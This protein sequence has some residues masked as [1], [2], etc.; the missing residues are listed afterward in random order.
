MQTTSKDQIRQWLES[1]VSLLQQGDI[2]G[3]RARFE[4]VLREQPNDFD[5]LNL[6]GVALYH[7]GQI[8][9]A[10]SRLERATRINP[11]NAG[12][13]SNLGMAL[14]AKGR[15]EDAV[16]AY[17]RALELAP[18]LVMAY[19][20]RARIRNDMRQF[21]LALADASRALKLRPGHA[22][23]LCLLGRALR[24]VGRTAEA[25]PIFDQAVGLQPKLAEAYVG[26]ADCLRQLKRRPEALADYRKALALRPNS[27]NLPGV[28]LHEQM[29]LCDWTDYHAQHEAVV[30]RVRKGQPALPPFV[31]LSILESA[32]LQHQAARAW[33]ANAGPSA[34]RPN[35]SA[36]KGPVR[37]GYF[38]ADFGDHPVM[39]LLLEAIALHDRSRFNIA[40]FT[41]QVKAHSRDLDALFDHV[42]DL[43]GLSDRDAARHAR[44]QG[45]DIAIDLDGHT[46]GARPQIFRHRAAPIQVSYLGYSGTAGA[47]HIDYMIA[48]QTIVPE[49]SAL[50]YS[51][52]MAWLPHCYMPRDRRLLPAVP[53][54]SRTDEGLPES[55]VVLC[56]FNGDFKITPEVFD[57]WM[58]ILRRVPESVLWLRGNDPVG[59][60]NLRREAEKRGVAPER[61]VFSHYVSLPDHFAR[62][63]HADL[64]LDTRPYN[65]H[66]TASDALFAGVPVL[67]LPG[68][69]FASRVAASLLTAI[70]MPE[71]IVDSREAYVETAVAIGNDPA[72]AAALKEKLAQNRETSPL[73]D[74]ESYTRHLEAAF[75]AMV[76][77]A[78]Q[79]LPPDHI[80][81][82]L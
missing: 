68:E 13:F 39:L 12:G 80:E 69:T 76:E 60:S 42:V 24:G 48:D 65:A 63:A 6:L 43:N 30:A 20:N 52:K 70:D 38:S 67:T 16:A 35:L 54:P 77:R 82:A 22:E 75:T 3:A 45:L 28:V 73:F 51:E 7:A 53:G 36:E 27:A 61:L 19:A 17:D 32:A 74:M 21:D 44:Q 55:G 46:R 78:R 5:A 34:D 71:L 59:Q 18:G 49:A 40:A 23:T 37:I 1:G 15:L 10:I 50:H 29:Q 9:E 72:R 11:D 81:V 58:D 26:R 4:Q 31:S 79:G 47:E 8:G 64:I 33:V 57:D 25:V 14:R 62:I 66:T 2:Q 41:Y 56:C